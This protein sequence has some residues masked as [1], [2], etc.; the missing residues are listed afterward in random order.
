MNFEALAIKA[1]LENKAEILPDLRHELF[2]DKYAKFYTLCLEFFDSN[3]KLPNFTEM[4][5]LVDSRAP[6]AVKAHYHAILKNLQGINEET[7]TAIILNELRDLSTLR[8][9]DGEILNLVEAARQK[10]SKEVQ[11]LLNKLNQKINLKGIKMH[12]MSDARNH[13]EEHSIV[14]SF[15]DKESEDIFLGSGHTGLTVISAV[16]GGGKSVALLQ[17]AINNYRDGKNVL[18]VTLELPRSVLYA[19][20]IS[21]LASVNF[22]AVLRKTYTPEEKARMDAAHDEFFNPDNPNQ[23]KI[24]DD[25]I[26]DAELVNLIAVQSQ[27]QGLDVCIIDYL[28]LIEIGGFGQDG[29]EGLSK[30]C[31]RLHKLTRSHNV[32]IITATQVNVDGKSKGSIMP[33]ISSRG[34]KEIE[35][36]SSQFLH[37]DI[38]EATGGLIMYT[39]KNRINEPMHLVLEKDF[40]YMRITST[41]IG[42]EA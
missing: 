15:L 41:G 7:S 27:L 26:T 33:N 20:L 12:E 17:A 42:L 30:L 3:H 29:W 39:K 22:N 24:I 36:S 37:L 8:S 31:K 16:P 2:T 11:L 4:E 25:S 6:T 19:R 28:Q 14:R 23:F 9:V 13:T 1:L 18:F 5:A 35:F 34:S 32:C 10:D 40:Q 38:D 21:N